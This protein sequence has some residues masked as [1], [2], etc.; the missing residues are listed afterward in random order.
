MTTQIAVL[1]A[2]IFALFFGATVLSLPAMAQSPE[3]TAAAQAGDIALHGAFIR[4][5]LPHATV[6]AA[7]VTIT[8]R[9]AT[10]ERLVS[11]TA[12]VGDHAVVHEMVEENEVM[13]MRSLPD[14]LVIPAGETVSLRPGVT[15]IMIHGLEAPLAVGQSVDLTLTFEA[16][17]DVTVDFDVLNLNARSHPD[18]DTQ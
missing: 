14:G 1:K 5:T 13:T 3:N 10:D 11:V 17:G 12:S 16:A 4:A 18:M 15:H 6:G 9:G 2:Y 7:Y 8:N